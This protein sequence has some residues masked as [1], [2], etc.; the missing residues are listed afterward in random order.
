MAGTPVR[1]QEILLPVKA[2][3]IALT[4]VAGVLLNLL[5]WAG[6]LLWIRPDFVAVLVLYWC[7][8]QPRKLGLAGAWALGLVM[9]IADA[10]LFG[11]HALVYSVLAFIAIV[12]H[13]RVLMFDLRHQMLHVLPMLLAAQVIMVL[14]HLVAG[15]GFPGWAYFLG[16]A[17]GAALW[18]VL[19]VLLKLPYRLK[20]D[21]DKV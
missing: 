16:S 4:F 1:A 8:H 14:V 6:A 11:Q 19:S 12:L 20:P 15:A 13:R 2:G 17:T 10:S 3:F 7:T 9:D 5:P 18:P 21:P